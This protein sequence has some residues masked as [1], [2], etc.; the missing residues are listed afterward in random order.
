MVEAG[1]TGSGSVSNGSEAADSGKPRQRLSVLLA[2]LM[3]CSV[4][5]FAAAPTASALPANFFGLQASYNYAEDEADMQEVG[6][7]G[8][9]YWRLGFNC[10]DWK[11]NPAKVWE[12]WDKEITLAWQ[13][14]LTVL[15]TVGGRCNQNS[16]Q[17][18]E[19]GE[20]N[21]S[22]S[23]WN[24]FVENLVKR[25]GY[26]GSFWS[27]KANPKEIGVW[28]VMNEPNRGVWGLNG[29]VAEGEYYGK[30]LK[31]VAEYIHAAQGTFFPTKVLFGGML[32]QNSFFNNQTGIW[33]KSPEDFMSEAALVG[34]LTSG[35]VNGVAIHPYAWN[36]NQLTEMSEYIFKTFRPA[37]DKSFGS[38]MDM[39]IT[40][41]GWGVLP[42]AEKGGQNV[43]SPPVTLSWQNSLVWGLLNW[44]KE[45]EAKLHL[46]SLIYYMYRDSIHAAG[47]GKWDSYAGL[48]KEHECAQGEYRPAWF[49]YQQQTGASPWSPQTAAL[50]ANT[51]NMLTWRTN[52]GAANQNLGMASGTSPSIAGLTTGGMWGQG[53]VVAFQANTTQLFV[54]TPTAG[55]ANTLF[56]MAAGTSPSV[57][58]LPHGGY[59]AAFQANTTEL[60]TYSTT[61]AGRNRLLG[62]AKGTSPS[63]AAGPNGNY[64]V[65]LQANTGNLF[66]WSQAEGGLN[67][68]FGMAAG[69]SPSI[70][71]L[72]SGEMVI[73]F[74]ANTGSLWV[75]RPN[76]GAVNTLLGM[77]PGTSPSLAV[78]KDGSY[79]VAIQANTS[80]MLTWTPAGGAVNS[81][82]G[83]AKGTS[84]SL[85][86]LPQGGYLVA[87][88]A[89]TSQ[90]LTWTPSG[91]AVNTLYGMA[92]GTSPAIESGATP[93]PSPETE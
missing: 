29:K 52:A 55:A 87:L 49:T 34:G 41:I 65:A 42:E 90:M 83:M 20:W 8:A 40:E 26:G 27:G 3:A 61:E 30:F 12:K 59:V 86:A 91:G 21:Y 92:S 63:V 70:G 62:M 31:A 9:K 22:G 76:F 67:R 25:Y 33:N 5:S 73:A 82:L 17:I 93:F 64:V 32:R 54:W 66:T 85:T 19:A 28:E 78:T 46:K 4:L 18:P 35:L 50:Q 38:S 68:G 44:A 79:A 88:Q 37:L 57:A 53:C 6:R 2:A 77:A 47:S 43:N 58:A 13:N 89:N 24:I 69:T 15:A 80:Q 1:M 16:V 81:L 36:N 60:F 56:G 74:Q 51:S 45:N 7:S 14:G 72:P 84:P 48:V 71:I 23:V 75:W 11:E 39:W 10:F